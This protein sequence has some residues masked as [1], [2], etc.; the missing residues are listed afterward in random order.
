MLKKEIKNIEYFSFKL[1]TNQKLA[2][3]HITPFVHFNTIKITNK[4]TSVLRSPHA[5]KNSQEQ[6]NSR[7]YVY[8]L[9]FYT[10]KDATKFFKQFKKL[11]ST[12]TDLAVIVNKP[13]NFKTHF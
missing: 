3:D 6:F 12:I 8:R 10:R 13:V 9:S 5:N 4:I 2:F 1:Y 11:Q 7:Y